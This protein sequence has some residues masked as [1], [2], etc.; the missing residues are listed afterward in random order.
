[1]DIGALTNF[2]YF[3]NA[4]DKIYDLLEAL[5]GARLT[6]SYTRIGGLAWDLPPG[7]RKAVKAVLKQMSR[8]HRRRARPGAEEPHLPG[9]HARRRHHQRR[10]R[11]F[12]S[13]GPGRA[14]APPAPISTC[15]RCGRTTV[16]TQFDFDV[17][18]GAN[19]DA[20]DRFMVRIAKWT[21]AS[22]SST[23]PSTG[24]P[25]G[26]INIDD[27]RVMLAAQ[28]QGAH[29]DGGAHQ[30]LQAGHRRRAAAAGAHLRRHRGCPMASS[31][32]TS[33]A[34]AADIRT[35]SRCVRRASTR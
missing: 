11:D 30:P 21:R 26:P 33:S 3:F 31:A 24:C 29:V 27:K 4:R 10:G 35:G 9:P 16:T 1:M 5:T 25:T 7:W 15:A 20:Y 34:T 12:A 8:R 22:G 17:P 28:R 18:V 23:R 13:V 2:W 6:Y 32:S 19:G 14:C